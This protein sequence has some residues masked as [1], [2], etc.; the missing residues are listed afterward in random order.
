M[1]S[2]YLPFWIKILKDVW[3]CGP[4]QQLQPWEL[5]PSASRLPSSSWNPAQIPALL[6]HSRGLPLMVHGQTHSRLTHPNPGTPQLRLPQMLVWDFYWSD[7]HASTQGLL[8]R[9]SRMS[10][11]T[12]SKFSF[13][14]Q[15]VVL[16]QLNIVKYSE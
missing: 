10:N 1:P 3:N 13:V 6:S 16:L 12:C 5:L 8:L 7:P 9:A 2:F 11:N 14:T 4:L 15:L